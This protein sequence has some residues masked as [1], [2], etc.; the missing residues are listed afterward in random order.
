MARYYSD[1]GYY[2]REREGILRAR[3]SLDPKGG[4]SDGD[5]V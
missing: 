4:N 5:R 1:E 3:M 2:A